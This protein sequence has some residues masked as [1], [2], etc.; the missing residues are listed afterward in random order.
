[1]LWI[2]DFPLQQPERLVN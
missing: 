2:H 1:M